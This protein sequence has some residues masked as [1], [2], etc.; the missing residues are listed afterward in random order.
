LLCNDLVLK[1]AGEQALSLESVPS[2]RIHGAVARAIGIEI[3]NGRRAPGSMLD[4]EVEASDA[5]GISRTAYREAIRILAAKGLIESRPKAGTR[6]TPR[7]RWNLLDPDVLAWMF[8]DDPGREFTTSLFE[9][10]GIVEPA[11]AALA[12]RRRSD[13][14]LELMNEALADMGRMTLDTAQGQA[15]DQR[16]HRAVLA[17]SGNEPL[18]TLASSVAAAVGWTTRFKQ[19]VRARPRDPMPDHL[20]VLAAI[21]AGDADAARRAM[22]EL[23]RLAQEDMDEIA[24]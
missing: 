22:E 24:S 10:R 23:L 5:L 4:G 8:S 12:A 18:A 21:R 14:D 7:S 16:F 20:A 15:A 17:A 3:V 1:S 9:L 19:R 11:A 2:P 6:V 13:A